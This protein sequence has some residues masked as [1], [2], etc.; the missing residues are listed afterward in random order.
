MAS[1]YDQRLNDPE[2]L[3]EHLDFVSAIK[4][5]QHTFADADDSDGIL[6]SNTW[7]IIS[8]D[9]FKTRLCA[10]LRGH[11]HPNDP[12]VQELVGDA[13]FLAGQGDRLL[14]ARTFLVL[15]SGTD[16]VPP[17]A[18]W[19]IQ[20]CPERLQCSHS[21]PAYTSWIKKVKFH[22]RGDRQFEPSPGVP[23]PDPAAVSEPSLLHLIIISQL[24]WQVSIHVCYYELE[25]TVNEGVRNLLR[26]EP[27]T[28]ECASLFDSW[29]HGAIFDP[30]DY[31]EL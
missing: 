29:F 24:F 5:S 23:I 18:H 19:S 22:H 20:V 12:N 25:V 30:H 2:V 26:Q 7:D 6:D 27:S 3:I 1:I 28:A 4:Q 8:E 14:R 13:A 21:H 10:Y 31:N 15:M 16:L 9:L 11:G 17:G